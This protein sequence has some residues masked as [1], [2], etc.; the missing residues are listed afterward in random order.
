MQ[1]PVRDEIYEE[2]G[3]EQG[4]CQCQCG[5]EAVEWTSSRGFS[6]WNAQSWLGCRNVVASLKS[7]PTW[8]THDKHA[9]CD[10]PEILQALPVP[11]SPL[12]LVMLRNRGQR[13]TV[14]SWLRLG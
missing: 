8:N 3:N 6:D 13:H 4:Q 10:E 1:S 5:S 2:E 11:V 7:K 12:E 14:S 9:Q